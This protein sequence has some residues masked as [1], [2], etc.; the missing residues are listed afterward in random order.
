MNEAVDNPYYRRYLPAG[1]PEPVDTADRYLPMGGSTPVMTSLV[2]AA[3]IRWRSRVIRIPRNEIRFSSRLAR[4]FRALG[5]RFRWRRPDNFR[6]RAG[7][8]SLNS[9]ESAHTPF[10]AFHRARTRATNFHRPN[11]SR[12]VTSHRSNALARRLESSGGARRVRP[13]RVEHR[14]PNRSAA[15]RATSDHLSRT[16]AGINRSLILHIYCGESPGFKPSTSYAG[17]PVCELGPRAGRPRAR[18]LRV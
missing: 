14:F 7:L 9:R 11:E 15:R 10:H 17:R 1:S 12:E 6:P 4:P 18:K 3:V 2:V 5:P 8:K 16:G 13:R